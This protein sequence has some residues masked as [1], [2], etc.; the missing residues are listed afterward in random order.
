MLGEFLAVFHYSSCGVY[1]G[2]RPYEGIRLI[3]RIPSVGIIKGGL[4]LEFF[5]RVL[6][7]L[8]KLYRCISTPVS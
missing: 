5:G 7:V 3:S 1:T 6:R 8:R 2:F 4:P